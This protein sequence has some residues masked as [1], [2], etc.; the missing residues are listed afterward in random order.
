MEGYEDPPHYTQEKTMCYHVALSVAH[1]TVLTI[2]EYLSCQLCGEL[3][4]L[5][6]KLVGRMADLNWT[7]KLHIF[8]DSHLSGPIST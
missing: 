5:L 8:Q 4:L 7:I 6:E 2:L 3:G 1:V